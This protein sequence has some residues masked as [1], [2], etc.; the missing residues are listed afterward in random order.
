[1][2]SIRP[3]RAIRP[4][5]DKAS[6]VASRSYLSYSNKTLKEKLDNNPFTF[7]HIIN[8]DYKK[9]VKTTGKEKYKLV[10]NKFQKFINEGILFEEKS[11]CL[12][13]YQQTKG[14]KNY[15]GII[16]ATSI[17]DYNNGN[18]KIHEQTLTKRKEMF[19][20]Y[21]QTTAF[22]AEPVLLTYRDNKTINLIIQKKI[23]ERAEYEFT[24]T[25]KVLHKF[26]NITNKESINS[27]TEEFKNI[28][29]IY[30]ADGHHRSA[31][32][33]L[34][35]KKIREKNP[36]YNPEDNFNF[37]MSYLI[38]E[39]ELNIINYNRLVKK[40]NYISDKELIVKIK[41][42]YDVC[43]KTDKFYSPTD[44]YEISMYLS[45]KWY[46][47]VAK[48]RNY[49]STSESLDP[50]ILSKYILAPIL[51]ITDEKTDKNISFFDGTIS[52]SVLKNKV[53]SGEFNVAFILKPIDID[54]LKKVSDNNEIMPPK[55][56]YIEPKLRSGLTIY[57]LEN[58]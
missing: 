42:K 12:Y 15:T 34:L 46:S 45:G 22:N 52:L 54:S 24:T 35:C 13:I 31:S 41:E 16:A 36:N 28:K 56:T 26:W 11:E 32:S 18:I 3:F 53:D 38:G 1:M 10:K 43:E 40:K 14:N 20:D 21:L 9:S 30:I 27:I 17:D 44:K 19:K 39:S 29:D 57:N 4:T 48:E 5:R 37:F 49:Q 2:A 55:S 6:L 8:P 51:G 58:K 25:N 47:L 50:S 7:L 33:S 23:E